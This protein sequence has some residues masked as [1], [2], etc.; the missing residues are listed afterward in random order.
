LKFIR[1][2][3]HTPLNR[4]SVVTIGNFDGVHL[5]H[6]AL[7]NKVINIAHEKQLQSVVVTMQPL[8]SEY[9]N[10]NNKTIVLTHFKSKYLLIKKLFVD[11]MCALNFN[12]SLAELTAEE[13]IQLILIDGL[14]AKH[15]IIGDDFKFGKNRSGDIH[16]LRRYC[17]PLG[18]S[19]DAIKS[20]VSENCRISSSQI[21]NKLVL[22]QLNK[23]KSLLGRCFSI[24][25]KVTQGEMLGR[26]LDFPTINLKLKKR[27]NPLHGIYCVKVRFDN[28][29][30]YSGA[31]SIGTRPTVAGVEKLLE[32]HI[33]DFNKQVY[34]QN[35]EVLFYHKIRNEVKFDNL[36]ELQRHIKDDVIKTRLY[37]NNNNVQ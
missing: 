27:H 6:Q 8:A 22:N 24:S 9:F 14:S 3:Q 36:D 19:I 28:G 20:V 23:V 7:I 15:I 21:R 32:V 30:E 5:G 29:K 26:T 37:F 33:L 31:A 1:Y 35:V 13:F 17:Q 10:K 18:I 2:P 16:V 4:P 12:K 34:G 25:G 11:C